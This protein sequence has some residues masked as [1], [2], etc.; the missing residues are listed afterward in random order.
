MQMP[1]H[2]LSLYRHSSYAL[3][4]E[5]HELGDKAKQAVLFGEQP[6]FPFGCELGQIPFPLPFGPSLAMDGHRLGRSC[7]FGARRR[8]DVV[9]GAD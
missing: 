1:S 3:W 4:A 7:G 2:Y 8:L 5:T 6:R 9:I